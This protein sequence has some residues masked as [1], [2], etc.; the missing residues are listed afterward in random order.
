MLVKTSHGWI[1]NSFLLGDYLS[2]IPPYLEGGFRDL[3]HGL[4]QEIEQFI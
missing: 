2:S 1:P 3:I 4:L